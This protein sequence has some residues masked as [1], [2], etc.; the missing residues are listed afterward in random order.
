MPPGDRISGAV[1]V[2]ELCD[3]QKWRNF[4]YTT[5]YAMA[6]NASRGVLN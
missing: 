5:A 2:L 4:R 3:V 1:E 6:S